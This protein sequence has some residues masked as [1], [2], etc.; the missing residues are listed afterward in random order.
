MP[1]SPGGSGR[2]GWMRAVVGNLCP[3]A[4]NPRPERQPNT[5]RRVAMKYVHDPVLL[6]ASCRW[7]WLAPPSPARA[8]TSTPPMRPPSTACC[9]NVGPAK[10]AGHRRL[11]QGQR[12]VPQPR[13]AGVGQGHRPEDRGEESR[14]D[15]DWR[16]ADAFH[17]G[18]QAG[19]HEGSACQALTG[20]HGS[21]AVAPGSACRQSGAR[22][23]RWNGQDALQG[24]IAAHAARICGVG[25]G[26]LERL[27]DG[28]RSPRHPA[29]RCAITLAAWSRQSQARG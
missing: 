22:K 2:Y 28:C 25:G 21:L 15:R 23:P 4:R 1:G 24:C 9:V 16:C 19:R 14:P 11:S 12:R 5:T 18:R 3:P 13:A 26:F 6:A 7:C 17:P 8:S 20:R 27:R 10:A 29:C